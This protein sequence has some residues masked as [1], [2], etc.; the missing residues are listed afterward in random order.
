M[1][2]KW[3]KVITGTNKLLR[4]ELLLCKYFKSCRSQPPNPS[5]SL[6]FYKK[7][8]DE[9]N[10]GEACHRYSAFFIRGMKNVCEKNMEEAF[11]YALKG[12]LYCDF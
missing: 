2:L 4:N 6:E 7:A 8:C 9:G 12:K 1:Q 10:I 3:E 5:K 11:K